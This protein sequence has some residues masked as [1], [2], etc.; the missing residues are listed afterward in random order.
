[1]YGSVKYSI[2]YI[3]VTVGTK[4]FKTHVVHWYFDTFI[5]FS[6]FFIINL[7]QSYKKLGSKKSKE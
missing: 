1:M 7:L 2:S 5:A 6:R 4:P 3:F